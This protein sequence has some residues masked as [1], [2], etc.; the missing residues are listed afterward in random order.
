MLRSANELIDTTRELCADLQQYSGGPQHRATTDLLDCLIEERMQGLL[1]APIDE[2][3]RLQAEA[4][5][6]K[7]IRHGITT[8]GASVTNL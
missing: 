4:R 1:T 3:S 7:S 5:L 8:P 6:L 2:L